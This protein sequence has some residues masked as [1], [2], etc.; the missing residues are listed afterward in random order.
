MLRGKSFLCYNKETNFFLFFLMLNNY[1]ALQ[2]KCED[3]SNVPQSG[4]RRKVL[5]ADLS[6]TGFLILHN[7]VASFKKIPWIKI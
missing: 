4:F 7:K 5:G 2:V 1:T 3:R 6:Y